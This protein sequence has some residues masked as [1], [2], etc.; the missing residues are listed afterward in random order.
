MSGNRACKISKIGQSAAHINTLLKNNIKGQVLIHVVDLING[1]MRVP[2]IH[3][4]IER[5]E[6]IN[7]KSPETFRYRTRAGE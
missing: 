4:C 2:K 5:M 3:Q 6:Y 7:K 1:K